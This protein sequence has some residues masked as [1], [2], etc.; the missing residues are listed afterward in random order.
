M[1][2]ICKLFFLAFL[3]LCVLSSN[4]LSIKATCTDAKIISTINI[5]QKMA[6]LVDPVNKYTL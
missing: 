4:S 5:D 1:R 6:A 3:S 2:N